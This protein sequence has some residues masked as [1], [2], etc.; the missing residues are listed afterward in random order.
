MPRKYVKK[1]GLSRSNYPRENIVEAMKAITKDGM[2]VRRAS[3]VY[4]VPKTTLQ[5]YI[6]GTRKN[7]GKPGV[8][9]ALPYD[10][11]L[12]LAQNIATLGD[13]GYA[14]DIT[15]LRHFV[16]DVLDRKKETVQ[17][18][19]DNVPGHDWALGF[20]QRHKD[21]LKNQRC[22][23]INR[24]RAAVGEADVAKYFECLH[25]VSLGIPPA[26]IINYDE[27]NLTDNPQTKKMLYRRTSKHPERIMN[28]TKTSISIMFAGSADGN[29]LPPYTV[30]KAEHIMS[31][32]ADNGPKDA[33]YNRTKSGW[34]DK[35]CFEDWFRQIIL[36][37][38]R[39]LPKKEWKVVIGDNLATHIS[40]SI[41]NSCKANKIHF[42]F[43]PPNSTHLLQPLDVAVYGP[44]KRAWRKVLTTWKKDEG[45]FATTLPKWV[46]PQLL[47]ALMNAMPN[48]SDLMKAGFA[49]CGIY[50]HDSERV[51]NKI[52]K[53]LPEGDTSRE[54]VSEQVV[55]MLRS[56]RQQAAGPKRKRAKRL[57][58]EPGTSVTGTVQPGGASLQDAGV[59]QQ[60]IGAPSHDSDLSDPDGSLCQAPSS[61]DENESILIDNYTVGDLVLVQFPTTE[62]KSSLIHY[63]GKII[64]ELPEKKWKVDYY[65]S[66]F[67]EKAQVNHHWFK[68][69]ENADICSTDDQQICFKLKVVRVLNSK[70][71]IQADLT[72]Y[73]MH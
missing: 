55:E 72:N 62:G 52:R 44:M 5:Q 71:C 29:I 53:E 49:A 13:F 58:V 3:T 61:D 38:V 17:V 56:M 7:I 73:C 39:K 65:R 19:N 21:L 43:L 36:P 31:T 1:T 32:W 10:F 20:L 24:N 69:P 33:K 66:I 41:I 68:K 40:D 34:F 27:T 18:F 57:H 37:Y 15:E 45:K 42:V 67:T 50:P 11:Q 64:E 30:Y 22:Q 54:Y 47:L 12:A 6:S 28:T 23:N 2:P 9:T 4:G 25:K 46:F 63:A 48:L 70:L 16:K 59:S 60:N 8:M 14:M 26:N 35:F 51:L